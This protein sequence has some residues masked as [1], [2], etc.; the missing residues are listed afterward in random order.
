[1]RALKQA[2]LVLAFAVFGCCQDSS[3]SLV[4]ITK[5]NGEKLQVRVEIADTPELRARGLMF[6]EE[7]PEG[8]G[9]LFVFP[10][11]TSGSFWMKNTPIPLD[12]I[13]IKDEE[14]VD[15]IENA[16]PYD[17]TLLTPDA[18]YTLVLEVPGGYAARHEVRV[19]DRVEWRKAE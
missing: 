3:V 1:M 14:I 12:L 11:E 10:A 7:L 5:G 15:L 18:P 19:G 2:L 8:T 16:V 6:R 17:E 9:M 13:F 4:G